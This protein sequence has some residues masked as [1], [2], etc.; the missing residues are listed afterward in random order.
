[1]ALWLLAVVGLTFVHD[2]VGLGA[3]ALLWLTVARR[4]APGLARRAL[5]AVLVFNATVSVGYAVLALARGEFSWLYLLRT[6]LRVWLITA[7]TFLMAK[8]VNLFAAL[9]FAPGLM[10][11]LTL[12]YTQIRIFTRLLEDFRLGLR[13]RSLRRPTPRVLYE[14]GAATGSFFLSK[15]VHD[16]AEIGLAMQARGLFRDRSG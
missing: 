7:C 5:L 1:L 13:S 16:A 12:A 2:L 11:V 3:A 15:A 9:S 6:N 14:H 4:D 10:M 8:R